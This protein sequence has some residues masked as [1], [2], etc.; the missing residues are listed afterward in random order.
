LVSVLESFAT[1]LDEGTGKGTLLLYSL[2]T[3][4]EKM[5]EQEQVDSG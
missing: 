3:G 1:L 2:A 4:V 5:E